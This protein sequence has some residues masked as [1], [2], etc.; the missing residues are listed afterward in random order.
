MATI[1]LYKSGKT[2]W[3]DVPISLSRYTFAT[4]ARARTKTVEGEIVTDLQTIMGEEQGVYLDGTSFL[5][6]TGKSTVGSVQ[7][8]NMDSVIFHYG[9]YNAAANILTQAQEDGDTR[10][11]FAIPSTRGVWGE[12]IPLPSDILMVGMNFFAFSFGLES[13]SVATEAS[14]AYMATPAFLR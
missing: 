11:N 9:H 4:V 2:T 5:D 1:R 13:S 14:A 6:T 8:F 3:F 10:G 12:I 7:L